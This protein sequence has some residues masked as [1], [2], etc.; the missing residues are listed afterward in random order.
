[1]NVIFRKSTAR[2]ALTALMWL[3]PVVVGAMYALAWTHLPR[4]AEFGFADAPIRMATRRDHLVFSLVIMSGL[5]ILGTSALS[6]FTEPGFD[7]YA[8]LG[9]FY[10]MEW[11]H[12][13]VNYQVI[14]LNAK[15]VP[16]DMSLVLIG[17]VG[18]A[19]AIIVVGLTRL[20][21]TR[22]ERKRLRESRPQ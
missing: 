14:I 17:G 4:T 21:S 11:A 22:S 1:M 9:F 16:I 8:V 13:Y 6:C 18:A 20:G 7:A 5:A 12:L 19:V 10:A 15:G 2:T 3:P